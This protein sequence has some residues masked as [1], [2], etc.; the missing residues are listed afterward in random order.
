MSCNGFVL[1]LGAGHGWSWPLCVLG[2]GEA[3]PVPSLWRALRRA[4]LTGEFQPV[5]CG[6]AL[7]NIGMQ[8][9]LDA[10]VELLPGSRRREI[11]GSVP[12]LLDATQVVAARLGEVSLVT[13]IVLLSALLSSVLSNAGV[14]AIL[15]PVLSGI[16]RK[17]RLPVSKLL[18]PLAFG[19][20]LGGLLSVIATSKNL[21]VNGILLDLGYEPFGL[22]LRVSFI[23]DSSQDFCIATI[24]CF[25]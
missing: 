14:V 23:G 8:P 15:V 1:T 7:R 12:M 5:L 18:M 11:Q 10:V 16:A 19:S 22:F 25:C 13:R 3:V 4:V 21:V 17:A 20:L 2:A 24:N 6:A 9:L